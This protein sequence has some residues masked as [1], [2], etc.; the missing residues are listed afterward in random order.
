MSSCSSRSGPL[1]ASAS[2]RSEGTTAFEQPAPSPDPTSEH[3]SASDASDASDD[4][5]G[6]EWGAIGDLRQT[7]RLH[8]TAAALCAA[9]VFLAPGCGAPEPEAPVDPVVDVEPGP[10]LAAAV[11]VLYPAAVDFVA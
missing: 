4:G 9:L 1:D 8:S 3:A 10:P 2:P 11:D 5:K 7:Q 6:E